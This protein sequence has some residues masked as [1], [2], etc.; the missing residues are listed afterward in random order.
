M[1]TTRQPRQRTAPLAKR[2]VGRPRKTELVTEQES[3]SPE[4][5][6]KTITLFWGL[7][8]YEIQRHHDGQ[9]IAVQGV[10]H[11]G[12]WGAFKHSVIRKRG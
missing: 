3:R 10:D 2:P 6:R 7:Y 9:Q 8:K 11:S 12:L 4:Q 5:A 1:P